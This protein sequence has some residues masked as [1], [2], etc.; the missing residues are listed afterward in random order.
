MKSETLDYV[1]DSIMGIMESLMLEEHYNLFEEQHP[2]L[3]WTLP[4][5]EDTIHKFSN[6]IYG[7][8]LMIESM[9]KFIKTN[10]L[11]D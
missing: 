2:G 10:K 6:K 8:E 3:D 4:K 7:K 1:L 5:F 11:E 9:V